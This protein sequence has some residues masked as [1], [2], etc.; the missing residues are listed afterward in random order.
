MMPRYIICNQP[1]ADIFERQCAAL[2]K[3]IA[4]LQKKQQLHDVDDSKTQLY[5]LN[6]KEIR[7]H[8]SFYIGEVYVESE[9]DLEPYFNK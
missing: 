4:G 5:D 6:G 7:V 9:I 8:N 1:D 2:E 3:N